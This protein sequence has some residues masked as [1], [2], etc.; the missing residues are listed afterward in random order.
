DLPPSFV[1]IHPSLLCFFLKFWSIC[2]LFILNPRFS[3]LACH[4]PILI[5]QIRSQPTSC[6]DEETREF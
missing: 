3:P 4:S 5:F 6:A 1:A 2:R